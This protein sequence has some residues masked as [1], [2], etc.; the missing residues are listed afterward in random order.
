MQSRGPYSAYACTFIYTS[1]EPGID[2]LQY[3]DFINI[4]HAVYDFNGRAGN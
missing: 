2:T 4:L 1:T 3:Y